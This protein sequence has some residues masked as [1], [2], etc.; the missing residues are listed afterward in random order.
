[1]ITQEL[2]NFIQSRK[3][4]GDAENIIT[5]SLLNS[6]W[7]LEDIQEGF[8]AL[9]N[10]AAAPVEPVTPVQPV[11]EVQTQVAVQPDMPVQPAPEMPAMA[12][13]M[14]GM[15]QH[16]V[17]SVVQPVT[18][19]PQT[20]VF[21][22]SIQYPAAESSNGSNSF[23]NV[24]SAQQEWMIRQGQIA[25]PTTAQ[26]VVPPM[27]YPSG[28]PVTPMQPQPVAPTKKGGGG[29]TC[30]IIGLIFGGL[31]CLTLVGIGIISAGIL[32]T[33]NPA[34]MIEKAKQ[35]QNKNNFTQ[36]QNAL[37]RFY[38]QKNKYPTTLDELVNEGELTEVPK[39]SINQEA[40]SYTLS[41]T[42][43]DY[44]LCTP[45][46]TAPLV[47]LSKNETVD[48]IFPSAAASK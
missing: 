14:G 42:G 23:A 36:I 11:N 40:Y 39:D 19:Q 4:A 41:S 47:C 35:V 5:A 2:L 32:A 9:L 27:I 12:Q 48:E 15:P 24:T 29:K 33:V 43:T 21:N 3:D 26:P 44:K 13:Q 46:S 17:Q 16:P 10:M 18:V 37:T 34:S 28:V 7:K 30:L 25:N 31:G 38:T 22:H 20:A 1:M 6:G 45:A 8:S